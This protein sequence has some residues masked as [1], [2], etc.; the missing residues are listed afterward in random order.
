MGT[1][2]KVI[3]VGAGPVGFLVALGLA[4]AGI[5][6]TVVD[7]EPSI[8]TSPRAAVY[9]PETLNIM[10]ALGV[11]E[12]AVSIG[13]RG[14]LLTMHFPEQ[15]DKFDFDFTKSLPASE[16]WPF[17]LHL[18]QDL[19]AEVV[20]THLSRLPN[21]RVLWNHRVTGLMQDDDGVTLR[22]D[23][24]EGEISERAGW[25][26]GADGAR[27]TIRQLLGL[28]F[29]GFTWPD[30]FV[31]TNVDYD[32][33]ARGF[34]PANMR[35]HP[36]HWAVIARL[37]KGSLW[38]VTFGEDAT[39]DEDS[40]LARIPEH[41][42]ELLPDDG[43]YRIDRAAPYRV[44]ERCVPNY[45][46]DRVLLAG[47]AAHVCNPCGGLGL[48]TGVMDAHALYQL[49]L[50]F[51]NGRAGEDVLDFYAEDRRRVFL[52]VSSPAAQG[53]K[54]QLSQKD[55]ARRAED[56]RMFLEM[57]ANPASATLS[58]SLAHAIMGRPLPL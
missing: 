52:E 23:T 5:D 54:T 30:R 36:E 11:A 41:Y 31:A 3:I 34:G 33:A 21:A 44:H 51:L 39:L 8:V 4:R 12:D 55:P 13:F 9:F 14:G 49:M 6:V 17:N 2:D 15:G 7:T 43:P 24:P 35:I 19:L 25:V 10:D 58:T 40:L 27:S 38:R 56:R 45:R 26:I 53:F 46:V 37:G 1:R 47:D 28:P 48:T 42:K 20:M 50:A 32:F 57:I 18:G 29:E 16:K 22:I